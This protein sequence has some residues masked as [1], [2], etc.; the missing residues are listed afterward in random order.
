M[1]SSETNE[2]SAPWVTCG[3]GLEVF[4]ACLVRFYRT[5]IINSGVV[6]PQVEPTYK[7][8]AFGT[9]R[10][11]VASYSG[12]TILVGAVAAVGGLA[13]IYL[14]AVGPGRWYKES[15]LSVPLALRNVVYIL[16]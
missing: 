13:V 9:I 11:V 8:K 12:P 5:L 6:S 3:G 2:L 7:H 16:L 4:R 15:G 10:D 14:L 1:P